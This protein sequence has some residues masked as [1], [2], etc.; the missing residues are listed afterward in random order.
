MRLL[1]PCCSGA[2][3]VYMGEVEEARTVVKGGIGLSLL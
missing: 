1:L 3:V 2:S